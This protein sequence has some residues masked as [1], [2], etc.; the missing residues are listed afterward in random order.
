MSYAAA[1]AAE[2]INHLMSLITT[3]F[4]TGKDLG[5]Y[6][7]EVESYFNEL[8]IMVLPVVGDIQAAALLGLVINE[9]SLKA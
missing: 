9:R 6:I 1:S 7:A 3:C 2:Y 4:E 5:D 8:A